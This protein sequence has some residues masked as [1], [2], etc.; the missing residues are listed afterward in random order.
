MAACPPHTEQHG[1]HRRSIGQRPPHLAHCSN[2]WTGLSASL[3]APLPAMHAHTENLFSTGILSEPFK[4]KVRSCHFQLRAL[5]W[6]LCSH[7]RKGRFFQ[8]PV[9]GIQGQPHGPLWS[10]LTSPSLPLSGQPRLLRGPKAH[11]LPCTIPCL[12]HFT[13]IPERLISSLTS[14]LRSRVT[15]Q[16]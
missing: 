7:I 1:P 16:G 4:I 13:W 8:M 10:P 14:D 12:V 15:S 5:Q 6:L 11:W 3:L 9:S 2:F